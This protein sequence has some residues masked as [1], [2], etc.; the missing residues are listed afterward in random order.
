MVRT[1]FVG[2]GEELQDCG[3]LERTFGVA[4]LFIQKRI[5]GK[6]LQIE[7]FYFVVERNVRV[8]YG[9]DEL[10]AAGFIENQVEQLA[11]DKLWKL[12]AKI[13]PLKLETDCAQWFR[14]FEQA[15]VFKDVLNH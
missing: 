3:W 11:E 14:L 13:D 5:R 1:F 4:Q 8:W 15:L 7:G 12:I 10:Y 9:E 2:K 6:K